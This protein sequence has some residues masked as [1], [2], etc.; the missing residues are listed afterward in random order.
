MH[1]ER[2]SF[3][4][5]KFT[6]NGYVIIFSKFPYHHPYNYFASL[7]DVAGIGFI[8]IHI[9]NSNFRGD[10]TFHIASIFRCKERFDP[11][12]VLNICNYLIILVYMPDNDFIF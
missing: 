1:V 7:F 10:D 9:E 4:N 2:A 8:Q 11:C 3:I 5:N 6:P 12:S